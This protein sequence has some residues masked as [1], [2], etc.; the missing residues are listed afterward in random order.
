M[1]L[2]RILKIQSLKRLLNI[3][4]SYKLSNKIINFIK[5]FS[6]YNYTFLGRVLKLFIPQAYLIEEN[7]STL[8]KYKV[9]KEN[10]DKINNN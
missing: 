8:V 2:W 3:I 5:F 7:Q 6:R 4:R 9:N 1:N 10:T